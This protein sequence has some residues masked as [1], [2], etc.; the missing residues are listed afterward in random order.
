MSKPGTFAA[1]A[2]PGEEEYLELSD[3]LGA[4]RTK[5][6]ELRTTLREKQKVLKDLE[7]ECEHLARITHLND[8]STDVFRDK[9]M[10][11]NAALDEIRARTDEGQF[12]SSVYRHMLTRLED[13]RLL[14]DK[15]LERLQHLKR[16]AERE[17][18]HVKQMMHNQK[19]RRNQLEKKRRELA[20][21]VR[22]N[23]GKR[24]KR[25][26]EARDALKEQVRM[27]TRRET[28]EKKRRQIALEVAGD[29][30]EEEEARLKKQF[31]TKQMYSTFLQGKLE[32]NT[33]RSSA[34]QQGFQKI[35]NATGLSDVDDILQKYMTRDETHASLVKAAK[36]TEAQ[37][38]EAQ[39]EQRELQAS[40]ES[41]QLQGVAG[42][43]NRTLYREI[44]QFDSELAEA[45]KLCG[46]YKER[47]TKAS[48]TLE[49]VRQCVVKLAR[50]LEMPSESKDLPA[51]ELLPD[52]LNQIEDKVKEIV[53]SLATYT[54]NADQR[55]LSQEAVKGGG[56]SGDPA[57]GGGEDA[58][59][60]L[61]ASQ[62]ARSGSAAGAAGGDTKTDDAGGSS[63]SSS[64]RATSVRP[65]T[66]ASVRDARS[67]I[68]TRARDML[69][70]S[71][72][73]VEP[74]TSTRNIR[75]L[76][77][78]VAEERDSSSSRAAEGDT[79]IMSGSGAS[80]QDDMRA[81]G[82]D[83]DGADPIVDRRRIKETA[84]S[85]VQERI[86]RQ[87][88]AEAKAAAAAAAAEKEGSK[89]GRKRRNTGGLMGSKPKSS[90][91]MKRLEMLLGKDAAADVDG[92]GDHFKVDAPRRPVPPSGGGA[93]GGKG[94][95]RGGRGRRR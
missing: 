75:V 43:G 49:D 88:R 74:D 66:G 87:R 55:R 77:K 85:L 52:I 90:A 24:E 26:Q 4:Q 39:A 20:D 69:Y 13:D 28:R 81:D 64:S 53:E 54:A 17:H 57:G 83:G 93:G 60:S 23:K 78:R 73:A 2:V 59:E 31:V 95:R 19:Q 70:S 37:I 29:L 36:E 11:L 82:K 16:E 62:S 30:G 94:K 25:L 67:V 79:G 80:M 58:V 89:G 72:M 56:G 91:D 38:E 41:I 40:L 27:Q 61:S 14:L 47:S 63:S 33:A 1:G 71:L 5:Y 68:G 6:D 32:K 42:Q 51:P 15:Q 65:P 50:K 9:S 21:Q 84:S 76:S 35:K 46:E 10:Q 48:M 34:L 44:D 3:F 86:A 8:T 18:H 45:R 22:V 7:G 92:T 12:R